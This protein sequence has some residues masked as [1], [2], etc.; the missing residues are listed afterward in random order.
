[1]NPM[2]RLGLVLFLITGISA[3]ILGTVFALTKADIEKQKVLA[4]EEAQKAVLPLAKTFEEKKIDDKLSYNEG[5]DETGKVIGYTF[6]TEGKGYSSTVVSIVGVD[7]EGRI[8]G[9][10]IIS[11]SETPGLGSKAQDE[12]YLAQFKSKLAESVRVK[13]DGGDIQPITGATI[14]PRAVCNSIS[15]KWAKIK[16]AIAKS[17]TKQV[18]KSPI[19][20]KAPDEGKQRVDKG[21]RDTKLIRQTKEPRK[22]GDRQ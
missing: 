14:T 16:D 11:Q 13:P 21:E 20:E 9:V 15:E 3:G 19:E 1:M 7:T 22:G 5:K 17:D 4:K 12:G 8:I 2:L 6:I 18:D 10:K